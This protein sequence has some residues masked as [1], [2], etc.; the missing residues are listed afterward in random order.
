VRG[1]VLQEDGQT[2]AAEVLVAA[3]LEGD[4]VSY[5]SPEGWRQGLTRL[6]STD[7]QGRFELRDV[8]PGANKVF[9]FA[10]RT[11]RTNFR[12]SEYEGRS[13]G[14]IRAVQRGIQ[15]EPG[16]VVE[17]VTLRLRPANGVISGTV[18]RADGTPVAQANVSVRG[19]FLYSGRFSVRTD[20]QGKFAIQGL[21]PGSHFVYAEAE[22]LAGRGM[23]DVTVDEGKPETAVPFTLSVGGTVTGRVTDPAGQPI[24]GTTV[25]TMTHWEQTEHTLT[26]RSTTADE[27]G[28]FTLQ[29]LAPGEYDLTFTT[30]ELAEKKV[31]VVVKEGETSQVEVVVEPEG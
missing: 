24:D 3:A 30:P 15:V 8:P 17:G 9:V 28:A 22:G 4:N 10:P 25:M 26:Q 1:Q 14:L 5:F 6:A 20:E 21:P 27:D 29:N 19:E 2:P 18:Q 12:F 31:K 11:S 13:G 23:K 7:S 16:G